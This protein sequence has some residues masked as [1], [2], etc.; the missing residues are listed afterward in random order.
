MGINVCAFVWLRGTVLDSERKDPET[1]CHLLQVPSMYVRTY[2]FFFF[3]RVGGVRNCMVLSVSFFRF[4]YGNCMGFSITSFIVHQYFFLE[5]S[6]LEGRSVG[7]VSFIDDLAGVHK[8]R[9]PN[10]WGF[11]LQEPAWTSGLLFGN[12]P[13]KCGAARVYTREYLFFS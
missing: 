10:F 13:N 2:V 3:L 9:A 4:S 8:R 6:T 5:R 11:Y 7:F 1:E 12:R